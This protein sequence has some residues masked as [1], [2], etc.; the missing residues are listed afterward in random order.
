M[1][2]IKDTFNKIIFLFQAILAVIVAMFW[3]QCY[4]ILSMSISF[5]V[6]VLGWVIL[7]I[8]AFTWIK[9]QKVYAHFTLNYDWCIIPEEKMLE[10]KLVSYVSA[11]LETFIKSDYMSVKT[12]NVKLAA[13]IQDN[14]ISHVSEPTIEEE[15]EIIDNESKKEEDEWELI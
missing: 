11:D 10:P 7:I 12:E 8:I 15:W 9:F 5:R 6:Y 2:S 4:N 13:I 1:N 14:Y 3:L